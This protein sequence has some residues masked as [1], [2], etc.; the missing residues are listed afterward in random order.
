MSDLKETPSRVHS[1]QVSRSSLYSYSRLG[2]DSESATGNPLRAVLLAWGQNKYSELG[3]VLGG[4]GGGGA[5]SGGR[6]GSA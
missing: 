2:G 3:V 6:G 1:D 5:G 4:G